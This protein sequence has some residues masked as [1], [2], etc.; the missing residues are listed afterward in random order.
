MG[1]IKTAIMSGA[2]LYGVKMVTESMDR[3]R[4]DGRQGGGLQS[5]LQ[6][7]GGNQ[8]MMQPQQQYYQPQPQQTPA[9]ALCSCPYCPQNAAQSQMLMQ[10]RQ[11]QYQQFDQ[12][13]DLPKYD[14]FN[15]Y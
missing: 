7:V 12:S 14:R 10:Q 6:G 13:D 3:N 2:G 15:R 11:Q 9:H 4:N 5:F 1:L 8:Q